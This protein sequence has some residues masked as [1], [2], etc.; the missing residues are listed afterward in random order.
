MCGA[1]VVR[2]NIH[3]KIKLFKIFIFRFIFIRNFFLRLSNT[4]IFKTCF[5]Y[6]KLYNFYKEENITENY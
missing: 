4:K 2:K 6:K 1:N 3:L 5:F